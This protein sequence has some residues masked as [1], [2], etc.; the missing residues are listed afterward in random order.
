MKHL[1]ISLL[2]PSAG[3]FF[4][5]SLQGEPE[6]VDTVDTRQFV[7]VFECMVSCHPFGF[8]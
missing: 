4:Q 8:L 6:I 7:L 1:S 3:E 2:T 5:A